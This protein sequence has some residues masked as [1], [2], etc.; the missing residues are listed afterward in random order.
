MVVLIFL[1]LVFMC[2]IQAVLSSQINRGGAHW[3][4]LLTSGLF[5][6]GLWVLL[7]KYSTN[8]LRDGLI[9]DV[10][11][12]MIFTIVFI[13]MG[14]TSNFETKHWVG[15]VATFVVFVYWTIIK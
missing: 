3:P 11:I 4:I 8:L 12:G 2:T 13:W 5:V 14:H 7:S 1:G 10:L 6:S 9:W 15:V